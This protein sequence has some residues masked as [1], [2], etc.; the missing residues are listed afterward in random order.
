M[1]IAAVD[2]PHSTAISL[3]DI[4]S[5]DGSFS[6]QRTLTGAT[7]I[8]DLTASPNGELFGV[9]G[10]S[11]VFNLVRIPDTGGA[12]MP[13][14]AIYGRAVQIG[15]RKRYSFAG[16]RCLRFRTTLATKA[17]LSLTL[18]RAICARLAKMTFS[19]LANYCREAR[20]RYR[21]LKRYRQRWRGRGK[22]IRTTYQM[23]KSQIVLR[24]PFN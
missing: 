12:I 7:N 22:A 8:S 17:Y 11:G 19:E 20:Y 6:N 23:R 4:N 9:C 1:L 21:T 18:T 10:I 24:V 16:I 13:V 5:A 2:D 15:R 3:I 14:G